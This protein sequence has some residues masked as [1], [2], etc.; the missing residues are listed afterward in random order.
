MLV[1]FVVAALAL[2]AVGALVIGVP[3]MIVGALVRARRRKPTEPAGGDPDSEFANLVAR[4]W[5]D[6]AAHLHGPGV[7]AFA[8]TQDQMRDRTPPVV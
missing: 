7:T 3:I 4:E 1:I 2:L 8:S 6:E 5:P